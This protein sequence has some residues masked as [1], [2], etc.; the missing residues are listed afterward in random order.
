SKLAALEAEVPSVLGKL[1][2]TVRDNQWLTQLQFSSGTPLTWHEEQA[3]NS[4]TF[5][6]VGR[7]LASGLADGSVR[8]WDSVT[9]QELSGQERVVPSAKPSPSG[10]MEDKIRKALDAPIKVDFKN[11]PL[12]EVFKELQKMS[13]ITFITKFSP[14]QVQ[15]A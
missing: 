3:A 6:P 13:G 9:G 10:S 7:Q 1:P 4:L 14:E 8:L 5:S 2:R 11:A 12:P 15:T